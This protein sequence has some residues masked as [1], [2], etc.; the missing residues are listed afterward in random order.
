MKIT[1]IG[2]GNIGLAL[3]SEVSLR[4]NHDVCLY[5]SKWFDVEQMVFQDV[6]KGKEYSDLRFR[7]FTNL[8]EAIKD[9]DYVFCT[10]PSFLR[11][12]FIEEA[13][14]IIPRDCRLGFVP[15]YGGAEYCCN[16]LIKEGVTVFGFQRVPYVARQSEKRVSSVMSR[17][18]NLYI[19]SIPKAYAKEICEDIQDMLGIPSTPLSEYLTVTLVPSNPLI[20]LTGLYHV[21]KNYKE[22][23]YYD[24]PMMFYEEWDDS[25]SE[26][27]F[28][29]D[30]ELQ[31]ICRKMRPIDLSG[32]V[33]LRIHYESPTPQALTKKLKSIPSLYEVVT[34][35][36][37]E[38]DGKYYPDFDSRMFIEDFPFGIAIIKYFALLTG[39]NTPTI[40]KILDF[41]KEKTGICYFE[42]DGTPGKDFCYSGAPGV[43]GLDTLEKIVQFYK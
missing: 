25:T 40:D 10:Y 37:K 2:G 43:Y 7:V 22:G 29:Y 17:K 39:C 3:A 34:V 32:V 41:Y 26:M 12:K 23:G 28:A 18:T 30:D 13:R 31:E 1:V 15:G 5:T 33:S 38:T 21:F 14:I 24:R 8:E 35:P 6:E 27:L 4:T 20:H 9:A 16:E 19:A 11:Q 42:E 36:L